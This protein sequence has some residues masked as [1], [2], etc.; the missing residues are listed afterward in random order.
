MPRDHLS[1]A[2]P[3]FVFLIDFLLLLVIESIYLSQ[4]ANAN[5]QALWRKLP[6]QNLRIQMITNQIK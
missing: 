5:S 3:F 6:Q 1:L 2:F 4:G